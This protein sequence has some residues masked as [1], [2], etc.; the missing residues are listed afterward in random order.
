MMYQLEQSDYHKIE[1]LFASLMKFHFSAKG[2][3]EGSKYGVI[4]VDDLENPQSAYMYSA[5][6]HFLGGKA[7]NGEFNRALHEL[8]MS[9][10]FPDAPYLSQKDEIFLTCDS[11]N[12]YQQFTVIFDERPLVYVDRRHYLFDQTLFD[13]KTKMPDGF[14]IREISREIVKNDDLKNIDKMKDWISGAW[15]GL[16]DDFYAKGTGACMM[17]GDDIVS[18]CFTVNDATDSC[19]LGMATAE[20]Y[21]RQGLGT[22]TAA[23]AVD[24]C[25]KKGFTVLDWHCDDNNK[26]SW[27][28]AQNA[29]FKREPDYI[30]HF[31]VY[32]KAVHFA[33]AGNFDIRADRYEK[34]AENLSEAIAAENDDTPSWIYIQAARAYAATGKN[35]LAI[36]NLNVAIDRGWKNADFIDACTE[37]HSLH[38]M[39][40]WD[41]TIKRL[42]QSQDD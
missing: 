16:F 13:W 8:I 36:S 7:D 17:K 33:L 4:Y 41:A 3:I 10:K 26:G 25:L 27:S 34:A 35:N 30:S 29:G 19:E 38:D 23:A 42:P 22:I 21:R 14:V 40:E 37:L 12:W 32:D 24:F 6:W 31:Y 1:P 28:I 20:E 2:V 5:A 39:A 15:F 9:P 18:W 11:D